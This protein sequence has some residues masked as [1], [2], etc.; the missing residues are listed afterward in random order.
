MLGRIFEIKRGGYGFA[1]RNDWQTLRKYGGGQL[2]NNGVHLIDQ[3][4]Q[5]LDSPV[6]A[7]FGDLQQI[8]NPGDV[9]DHV[10]V[11]FR[12]ESGMVAD[13]EITQ[14]ALPLPPWVVLGHAGHAG[15]GRA[16]CAAALCGGQ[17]ASLSSRLT[18][19][20]CAGRK[21][22]TGEKLEF[23]EETLPAGLEP[24]R[25]FYDYLAD[26]IRKGKPLFVSPESV[27]N[28]M[29]VLRLARKGTQFA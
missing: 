24:K 17:A 28:T 6:T 29:E 3:V 18:P 9:E 23:K 14:S 15:V 13:V 12:A 27:R 4:V 25:N 20:P 19:R 8:L 16:E 10:K 2:N 26:S 22:G 11:V 7:V 21:Y 5:L 1:R